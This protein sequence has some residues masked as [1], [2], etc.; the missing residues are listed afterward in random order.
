MHLLFDYHWYSTVCVYLCVL[1]VVAVVQGLEGGTVSTATHH[2]YLC[3]HRRYPP[4]SLSA[5]SFPPTAPAH[6]SA[7][8]TLRERFRVAVKKIPEEKPKKL[9]Q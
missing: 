6:H 8:C 9:N 4:S 2:R 7:L 5:E 1:G 3:R